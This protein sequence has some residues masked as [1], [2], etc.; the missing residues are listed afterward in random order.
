MAWVALGR[1]LDLAQSCFIQGQAASSRRKIAKACWVWQ[2]LCRT[3]QWGFYVL[4][5]GCLRQ[6][7][8]A[9]LGLMLRPE[10][11]DSWLRLLSTL[12]LYFSPNSATEEYCCVGPLCRVPQM[13]EIWGKTGGCQDLKHH[14][15]GRLPNT[16]F[17]SR[18]Y[19][20]LHLP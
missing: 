12:G 1:R 6:H 11:N 14:N 20:E 18:D 2:D 4:V 16:Q 8:A 5:L 15:V 9:A 7:S 19:R 17:W 3:G 10:G 13:A